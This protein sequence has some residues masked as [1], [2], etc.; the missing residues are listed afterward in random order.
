[1]LLL[2]VSQDGPVVAGGAWIGAS[3]AINYVVGSTS[4]LTLQ[5]G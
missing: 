5:V 1:M 2:S 3:Y 4:P